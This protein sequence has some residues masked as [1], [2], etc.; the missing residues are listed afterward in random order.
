MDPLDQLKLD[1]PVDP[2]T[3][4]DL[5]LLSES[6][7][8]ERIRKQSRQSKERKRLAA[9]AKQQ[10]SHQD[11]PRSKPTNLS[12]LSEE[13]KRQHRR[14]VECKCREKKKVTRRMNQ[15]AQPPASPLTASRRAL[16]RLSTSGPLTG[17]Q[18][19][20]GVSSKGLV[21]KVRVN[22]HDACC[23]DLVGLPRCPFHSNWRET[24]HRLRRI[25]VW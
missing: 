20:Q 13:E 6:E 15:G 5:S 23:C 4:K 16:G 24:I 1:H 21:C 7:K 11:L 14:E 17:L 12:T 3:S 9:G 25:E 10:I 22:F 8:K 18:Q 2:P 19:M